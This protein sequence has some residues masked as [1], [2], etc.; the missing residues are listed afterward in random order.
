MTH[1]TVTRCVPGAY[2]SAERPRLPLSPWRHLVYVSAPSHPSGPHRAVPKSTKELAVPGF[3]Y[4]GTI[5]LSS[6]V[7][8]LDASISWFEDAL[9]FEEIFKAAEAGWAEVSTPAEG[10]S[11]GL[12]QTDAD[13][14]G[15]GGSIP[16]FG[17]VDIDAARAE[18]EAKGVKFDGETRELPGMVKLATFFDP[19]GNRYMFA[20]SLVEGAP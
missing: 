2:A 14:G 8:D 20:Q 13:A 19:D 9:G 11:I 16:V 12:D 10:V 7:K 18:L 6:S 5:T 15:S 17:V 1:Q 4:N 3:S